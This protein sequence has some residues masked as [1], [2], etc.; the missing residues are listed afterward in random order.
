MIVLL[1]KMLPKFPKK[2][3]FICAHHRKMPCCMIIYRLRMVC[4]SLSSIS[5][6]EYNIRQSDP[7]SLILNIK[8]ATDHS[9]LENIAVD[10]NGK[11]LNCITLLLECCTA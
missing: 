11:Y 3:Y 1:L 9:C 6:E 10:K 2:I 8:G 5:T 7:R 4:L